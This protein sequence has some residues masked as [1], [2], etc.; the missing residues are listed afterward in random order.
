[1]YH[2][3]KIWLQWEKL[4]TKGLKLIIFTILL[5]CYTVAFA[6]HLLYSN[7][8]QI[9]EVDNKLGIQADGN[10]VLPPIYADIWNIDG[11]YI[12]LTFDEKMGFYN[13][14]NEFYFQPQD[15][16][17]YTF[18]A[19]QGQLLTVEN[20]EGLYGFMNCYTGE[21]I[22]PYQFNGDFD[23]IGCKNGFAL[24]ANAVE[25]DKGIYADFFLYSIEGE[26]VSFPEG[27][28][29]I[30]QVKD[31]YVV[32]TKRFNHFFKYGLAT[33]YGEII[34]WPTFDSIDCIFRIMEI[35]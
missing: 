14:E 12:L 1:M 8:S 13:S 6:E 18:N 2:N 10:W 22:I 7:E 25:T 28:M 20:K 9:I 23:N 16:S 17:I 19:E 5:W 11:L 32:I 15:I 31:G 27:I 35:T 24:A 29:P 26:K 21:M 30:S 33:C 34:I 3:D 4:M